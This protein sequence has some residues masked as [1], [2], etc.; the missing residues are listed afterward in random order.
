REA[1][2]A[3]I[4]GRAHEVDLAGEGSGRHPLDGYLDAAPGLDLPG[5]PL[6]YSSGDLHGAGVEDTPDR[7][8]G[9][10]Q[11]A[12]LDEAAV[13]DAADGRTHDGAL[14]PLPEGTGTGFG[15]LGPVARLQVGDL[16][17]YS[18]LLPEAPLPFPR[19]AGQSGF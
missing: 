17:T 11:G 18:I 9:R 16:G 7:R 15:R 13:Q 2:V 10:D 19:F 3:Q 12:D 6:G 4:D 1:P 5:V 8:P 14:E